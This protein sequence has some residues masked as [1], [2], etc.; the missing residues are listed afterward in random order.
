MLAMSVRLRAS[1]SISAGRIRACAARACA[2]WAVEVHSVAKFACP[3]VYASCDTV[4][5]ACL[6]NPMIYLGDLGPLITFP[7]EEPCFAYV[8][9]ALESGVTAISL[10]DGVKP[11][12]PWK[13]QVLRRAAIDQ[14]G[15]P[16]T[17]PQSTLA[18]CGAAVSRTRLPQASQFH[19]DRLCLLRICRRNRRVAR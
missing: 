5:R 10:Q 6:G 9:Q 4:S 19:G 13:G 11:C 17:A 18:S 7:L 14:A 15:V 12:A 1:P 8:I 16:G 3:P 2:D